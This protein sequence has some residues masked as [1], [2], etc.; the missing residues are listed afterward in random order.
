[1]GAGNLQIHSNDG[2][3]RFTAATTPT[4]YATGLAA[5]D[6]DGDG[7]VDLACSGLQLLRNDGAGGFTDVTTAVEGL[8]VPNASTLWT[9]ADVDRNGRPDLLFESGSFFGGPMIAFE[10]GGAYVS[11][12][13]PRGKHLE[14]GVDRFALG[15]VDGDGDTDLLA[16]RCRPN[17]SGSCSGVYD[18]ELHRNDGA[19]R[20]SLV[21]STPLTTP[22]G[23]LVV[24]DLDGD[25]LGDLVTGSR[26]YRSAGSSIQAG[27]TPWPVVP[28]TVT[29]IRA[30][31]ADRDNDL[32]VLLAGDGGV[33]LLENEAGVFTADPSAGLPLQSAQFSE[34]F[35]PDG[36]GDADLVF[37]HPG[38]QTSLYLNDGTGRFTDA[39]AR[40]PRGTGVTNDIAAIDADLDGDEDLAVLGDRQ[41]VVYD[42]DGAGAFTVGAVVFD[43][44]AELGPTFG[45]TS[46]YLQRV[47]AMDLDLD[48]DRDLLIR[49]T[50]VQSG[51]GA[52]DRISF[53]FQDGAGQ[54]FAPAPGW[55]G[56]NDSVT[57]FSTR[58]NADLAAADLDDDGDIDV[59]HGRV[60]LSVLR[61]QHR[62]FRSTDLAIAGST[63][64]LELTHEAGFAPVDRPAALLLGIG[65]AALPLPPLGT[66]R[67]D[68]TALFALPVQLAAPA[69]RATVALPLPRG[70]FG[71]GLQLHSQV[72]WVDAGGTALALSPPVIDTV[73]W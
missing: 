53:R 66:V 8:D 26:W 21:A 31:D 3:G 70:P 12:F 64:S 29:D 28:G 22:P 32:D 51:I 45:R 44:F 15:D 20:F 1:M 24:A 59:V 2:T 37:V 19:G 60:D 6:A 40:L 23:Y 71:P 38:A 30:F 9:W 62:G 57:T 68:P 27:G 43:D 18:I 61:N 5:A 67:I 55:S 54:F 52:G 11:R 17:L 63:Y 36:D 7:D 48:G 69:G 46:R 13:G 73:V 34:V 41:L 39:T 16:G 25:G 56:G 65:A 42:N 4:V 33:V 47:D 35:D 58:G 14:T 50:T 49:H 10:V 72:L